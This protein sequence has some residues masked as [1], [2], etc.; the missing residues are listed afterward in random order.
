MFKVIILV[1]CFFLG[2]IVD[3]IVY[4]KCEDNILEEVFVSGWFLGGKV[5]DD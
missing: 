2:G 5:V 4:K 3:I 1:F